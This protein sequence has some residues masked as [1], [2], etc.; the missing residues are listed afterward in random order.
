MVR[1]RLPA[2]RGGAPTAA[3][4]GVTV[5]GTS[6]RILTLRHDLYRRV[7]MEVFVPAA[8]LAGALDIVRHVTD[9]FAGVRPLPPTVEALIATHAPGAL[10]DLGRNR[11]RYTHHDVI[12]RRRVLADDTL[13]SMTADGREAYALGFFSY[14]GLEPGYATSG[15]AI[16]I[17]LIALCGAR[18]HR[19]KYFPVTHEEAVRDAYPGLPRFRELCEHD[20]RG[21]VFRNRHAQT[22]LGFP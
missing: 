2:P 3:L 16:A 1:I 19:G 18:V 20:D 5:T 7:E 14:R 22:T 21:G 13:I 17:A 4:R 11:G 8:A 10:V 15:R 12:P 9:A 6:D